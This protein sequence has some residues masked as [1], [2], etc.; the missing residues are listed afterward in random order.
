[1]LMCPQCGEV[2]LGSNVTQAL[3]AHLDNCP[4]PPKA[5]P[6]SLTHGVT[7]VV[8]CPRVTAPCGVCGVP[9]A[10]YLQ[11]PPSNPKA[12]PKYGGLTFY[13]CFNHDSVEAEYTQYPA[14]R[15]PRIHRGRL[16]TCGEDIEV[17]VDISGGQPG[18]YA[19]VEPPDEVPTCC[20]KGHQFTPTEV[21]YLTW[22]VRQAFDQ[23]VLSG[24]L[25]LA[26]VE[27][28]LAKLELFEDR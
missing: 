12:D 27:R 17:P 19:D 7:L 8:P 16:A 5:K 22:Q 20:P 10:V 14:D 28:D 25:D 1:M 26:M 15:P 2:F 6:P 9:A 3:F 23:W 4:N 21:A 24:G 13:R 11:G 18:D